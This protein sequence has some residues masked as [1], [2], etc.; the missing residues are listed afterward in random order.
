[1]NKVLKTVILVLLLSACASDP[2]KGFTPEQKAQRVQD[3]YRCHKEAKYDSPR[4]TIPDGRPGLGGSFVAG[5]AAG[6]PDYDVVL[7]TRCLKAAG[8]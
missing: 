5:V 3:E 2:Y 4:V 7:Y 6:R 1:M 8:W